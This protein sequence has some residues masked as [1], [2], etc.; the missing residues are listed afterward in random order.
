MKK[1][2]FSLFLLAGLSVSLFSCGGNGDDEAPIL[3]ETE[4]PSSTETPEAIRETLA[5]KG[6]SLISATEGIVNEPATK[7][8]N[9]FSLLIEHLNEPAGV[10]LKAQSTSSTDLLELSELCGKY[11]YDAAKTSWT[12]ETIEGNK[13][14]FIFP[15]EEGGSDNNAQIEI[16]YA[17]TQLSHDNQ[18]LTIP[19]SVD[20]V[21]TVN[22]KKEG[23]MNVSVSNMNTTS[24]FN[25]VTTSCILG[26]YSLTGKLENLDNEAKATV[27]FTANG[28]NLISAVA[29]LDVDINLDNINAQD[30]SSMADGN[31]SITLEEDIAI[32]GYIDVA[33]IMPL[34]DN[35]ESLISGYNNSM[36]SLYNAYDELTGGEYN[37]ELWN[38]YYSQVNTLQE[39]I[40]ELEL[41]QAEETQKFYSLILVSKAQQKR[42]ADVVLRSSLIEEKYDDWTS[43]YVEETVVFAFADGV[44]V[45]A[46]VYFGTGFESVLSAL[47]DLFQLED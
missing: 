20:A 47:E 30:Y 5:T 37:E 12:T 6:E 29:D 42:L 13:A 45:D 28:K 15:A 34:I 40:A 24:L 36:D 16:T 35:Y 44:E 32:V 4:Y 11:T 39:N 22:G 8:L 18:N 31:L 26:G 9:S 46:E 43:Y 19:Q 3:N 14:V 1:N 23:N 33:N 27:N 25:D 7:A 21:I 17:N 41:K 2:I 38:E 10:A